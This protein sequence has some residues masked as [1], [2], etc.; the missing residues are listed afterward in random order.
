MSALPESEE[1][2]ILEIHNSEVYIGHLAVFGAQAAVEYFLSEQIAD[3]PAVAPSP[4]ESV[5]SG[6]AVE[7]S[8]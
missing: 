5:A 1:D 3:E 2:W 7:H 4:E 6:L 8:D